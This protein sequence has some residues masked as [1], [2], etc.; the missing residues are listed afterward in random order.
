M[1]KVSPKDKTSRKRRGVRFKSSKYLKPGALAQMRY[2]KA[3]AAKPCSDIVVLDTPKDEQDIML[4]NDNIQGSPLMMSPSKFLFSPV[5][6]TSDVVI[7]NSDLLRTPK[8]PSPRDSE[9]RLEAL[10]MDILMKIICH[11]HHDQLRAV[12]HVSQRVRMAVALARQFYFNYTTPDRS[13]QE[14]LRTITPCPTEHWPFASKRGREGLIIASPHAPPRV[15]RRG[16]R[17]PRFKY[18]D[19]RQVTTVLFD[20]TVFPSR[21]CMIPSVLPKP[22]CKSFASN[23]VLFNEDELC[24]AV[25][26]NKLR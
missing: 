10:P 4:V 25:A 26:Q 2:A 3:S 15:A 6:G 11:L 22:S 8:T 24:H 16:V 20:E 18:A 17:P 13:R 14:M 5:A 23:R 21:K 9:S 12:F 19:M 7:R 1:G